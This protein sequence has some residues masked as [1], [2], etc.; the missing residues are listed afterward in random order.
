MNFHKIGTTKIPSEIT[1]S[2]FFTTLYKFESGNRYYAMRGKRI[3]KKET[4]V[5]VNSRC[6]QG[7]IFGSKR[8]DCR[9]QFYETLRFVLKNN[10]LFIYAFDQDGRGIG[11]E[12]QME[13]YM[14]G[15]KGIDS[16]DALLKLGFRAE[17]REYSEVGD[18]IKDFNIKNIML[19]TNNP[20]K[21]KEI[22]KVGIPVK[23][24]QFKC[25][26]KRNKHNRLECEAKLKLGHVETKNG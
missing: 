8:C 12:K 17:E 18:I 2:V 22:S 15:D 20:H 26:L 23:M 5:R 6:V 16:H 11:L 19:V 7:H 9:R 14:L 10:G 24:Y 25:T 13:S 3:N 4:F 1:N 21:V